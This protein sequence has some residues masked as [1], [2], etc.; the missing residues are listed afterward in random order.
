MLQYTG[1]TEQNKNEKVCSS[2]AL[3]VRHGNPG[4]GM[5]TLAL[6]T[7]IATPLRQQRHT[8]WL[9]GRPRRKSSLS[10]DGRSSCIN[11]M[12]WTISIAHAVGIAT[13]RSPPTM[14]H[15]ARHSAGRTRLPP[16]SS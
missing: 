15:A 1:N 9:V 14:S 11:D 4:R 12:V 6:H 10:M 3:Q 13:C 8:L 7:P 16:A 5:I 2:P